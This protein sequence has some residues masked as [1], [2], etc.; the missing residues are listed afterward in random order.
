MVAT[1]KLQ[2][3]NDPESWYDVTYLRFKTADNNTDDQ[4]N[5]CVIPPSG[6]NYSYEKEV[7]VNVSVAPSVRLDNL[8]MELEAALDTGLSMYYGWS[9][10][11]FT[12]NA[13]LNL[14]TNGPLTTTPVDW[15][16]AADN[17]TGTGVWGDNCALQIRIVNTASPGAM[18]E[19][20]FIITYD[21]I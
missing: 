7:R 15:N 21:E 20:D 8:T 18:T 11:Y 19:Q 10:T 17:F 3:T 6:T 2:A 5:P 12:P 9:A 14:A 1:V 16:N 4:N 13:G